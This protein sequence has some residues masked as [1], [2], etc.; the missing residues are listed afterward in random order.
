MRKVPEP[1]MKNVLES[2]QEPLRKP[3]LGL[4]QAAFGSVETQ[5]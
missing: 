4:V 2:V 5:V 1:M 3:L